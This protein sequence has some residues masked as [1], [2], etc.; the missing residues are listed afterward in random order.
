MHKPLVSATRYTFNFGLRLRILVSVSI[1]VSKPVAS[2][3]RILDSILLKVYSLVSRIRADAAGLHRTANDECVYI[4]NRL[5]DFVGLC[6]T[7]AWWAH[8]DSNLEPKDYE[9]RKRRPIT[10]EGIQRR[11]QLIVFAKLAV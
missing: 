5:P 10:S 2:K 6:R 8:Q 7:T 11:I 1:G 4:F 9:S 3:G